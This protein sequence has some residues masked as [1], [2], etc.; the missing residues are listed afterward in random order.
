VEKLLLRIC[1][2]V[3]LILFCK[4]EEDEINLFF[5]ND[6]FYGKHNEEVDFIDEHC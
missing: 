2:S 6:C 4:E 5:V 1:R 3:A